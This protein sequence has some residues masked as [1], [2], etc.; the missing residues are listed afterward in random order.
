MVGDGSHLILPLALLQSRLRGPLHLNNVLVSPSL[1]PLCSHHIEQRI[2]LYA[3]DVVLFVW[4]TPEDLSTDKAIL[5]LFGDASG[6]QTNVAKSSV[7]P[8]RC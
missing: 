1:Q 8:I 5:Q 3:D 7:V 6:L 4:P 2:S